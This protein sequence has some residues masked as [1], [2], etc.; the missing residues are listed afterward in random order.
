MAL[1]MTN[2]YKK[3]RRTIYHKGDGGRHRVNSAKKCK[4]NEGGTNKR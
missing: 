1:H 2:K 3:N 4:L